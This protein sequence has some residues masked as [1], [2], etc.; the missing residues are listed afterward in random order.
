MSNENAAQMKSVAYASLAVCA[1][2]L[3]GLVAWIGSEMWNNAKTA[4][5]AAIRTESQLTTLIGQGIPAIVSTLDSKIII[6]GERVD[7]QGRRIDRNDGA[8]EDIRKR[9]S[10]GR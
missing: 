5:L 10:G 1:P 2:I 8:L 3:I 4:A 7:A 9:G 6:L